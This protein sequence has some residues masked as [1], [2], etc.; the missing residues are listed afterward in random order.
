MVDVE[1]EPHCESRRVN[2]VPIG[3]PL[4]IHRKKAVDTAKLDRVHD[5]R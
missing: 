3:I 2:R 4:G 1:G 5:S